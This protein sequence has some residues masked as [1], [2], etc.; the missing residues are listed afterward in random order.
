MIYIRIVLFVG[1]CSIMTKL[2]FLDNKFHSQS[3]LL[4]LSCTR[5]QNIYMEKLIIKGDWNIL[6]GKL[7]QLYG[8]LT[9][10]DLLYIKGKEEELLGRIQRRIGKTKQQVIELLSKL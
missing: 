5:N 7:K 2:L 6:K 10:D 3:G 1:D 4:T 9:D 8:N